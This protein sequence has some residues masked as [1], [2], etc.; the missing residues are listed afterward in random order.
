MSATAVLKWIGGFIMFGG[1]WLI[2]DSFIPMM[3]A[4]TKC[5][6]GNSPGLAHCTTGLGYMT[7]AW[8]IMLILVA[9]SLTFA[10]LMEAMNEA[11]G[12]VGGR[13]R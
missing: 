5:Q 6:I 11:G 13:R 12:F 1:W 8:D 3:F 10:F 2:F 4:S 7:Q 9:L